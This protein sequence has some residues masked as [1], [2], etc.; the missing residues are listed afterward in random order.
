MKTQ[1]LPGDLTPY[2]LA[3]RGAGSPASHWG[4]WW[5][6]LGSGLES[7][8]SLSSISGS[9]RQ[10][11]ETSLSL[12]HFFPPPDRTGLLGGNASSSLALCWLLQ[13]VL[14]LQDCVPRSFPL[15]LLPAHTPGYKALQSRV[16]HLT[17][18]GPRRT[19]VGHLDLGLI[20]GFISLQVVNEQ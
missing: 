2:I 18:A 10:V 4:C 13:E 11:T 6:W 7:Q 16:G 12:W 15:C 1:S 3:A 5:P 20:L 8:Y 9:L 14:D 19:F 17:L